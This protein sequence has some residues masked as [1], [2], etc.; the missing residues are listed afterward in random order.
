MKQVITI[1]T[2]NGCFHADDVVA[3]AIIKTALPGCEVRF[4]RTRDAAKIA[5]ADIA[6]D[7]GCEYDGMTRFDHH[8]RGGAGARA[9]GM[10]YAA[11]GLVWKHFGASAVR[12]MSATALPEDIMSG[13]VSDVDNFLIRYVDAVDCGVGLSCPP[14]FTLSGLIGMLNPPWCFDDRDFDSAFERAVEV[15]VTFLKSAIE[16]SFSNA[17][18]GIMIKNVKSEDGILVLDNYIPWQ[19]HVGNCMPDV[20]VVIYPS[21]E[22]EEGYKLRVAPTAE[23]GFSTRIKLPESWAGREGHEIDALTGLSGAVFC[24]PGRFI[25]GHLTKDGAIAMAKIAIAECAKS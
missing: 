15:A 2:H 7:V 10:P 21:Y 20:L 23:L 9:N 8:Q 6:V 4:V 18:A 1:A 3:C 11:A 22:Q 16:E 12:S 5:E 19:E 17:L 25:A 14:K 24:H 13:I